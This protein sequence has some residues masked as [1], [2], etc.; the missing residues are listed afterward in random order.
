M[1]WGFDEASTS[2]HSLYIFGCCTYCKSEWIL[3]RLGRSELCAY[4]GKFY[5][6]LAFVNYKLQCFADWITN[7][8]CE[9]NHH[10][11]LYS[12]LSKVIAFIYRSDFKIAGQSNQLSIVNLNWPLLWRSARV[13]EERILIFERRTCLQVFIVSIYSFLLINSNVINK[14]DLTKFIWRLT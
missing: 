9:S 14:Y 2:S 11:V 8:S 10:A 5:F 1:S 4:D 7:S 13:E 6:F 12:T 3:L